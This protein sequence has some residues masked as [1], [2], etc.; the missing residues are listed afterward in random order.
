MFKKNAKSLDLWRFAHK[1]INS[2][3][4]LVMTYKCP[5]RHRTGCFSMLRY[6]ETRD[7]IVMEVEG[8]HDGTSHASDR[9][10]KLKIEHRVAVLNAVTVD[11]L[12][13]VSKIRRNVLPGD[14]QAVPKIRNVSALVRRIVSRQHDSIASSICGG[15]RL[16]GSISTL[17]EYTDTVN[18]KTLFEKHAAD[19]DQCHLDLHG[20][21]VIGRAL[22]PTDGEVTIIIS[23]VWTL[24]NYFR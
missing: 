9:S 7:R 8:E 5:F 21:I 16:D 11:P 17:A 10:K 3:N 19:T 24:L 6:R 22:N 4:S 2:D 23:N 15:V 13:L 12:Q 18:M 1:K 20:T 14:I